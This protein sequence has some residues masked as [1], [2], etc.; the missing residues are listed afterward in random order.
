MSPRRPLA[1]CAALAAGVLSAAA[2]SA[3]TPTFP[4]AVETVRVDVLVTDHRQPLL[5]LAAGDFEVLDNGVPQVV[6][7]VVSEGLPLNVVLALDTSGSLTEQ[8]LE[9][10]RATSRA[11]VSDLKAGDRAALLTFSSALVL[12]AVQPK[13]PRGVMGG[14]SPPISEEAG[15]GRRL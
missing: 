10:L 8:R 14:W 11:I 5:G 9:A 3:Q 7:L 15:E 1:R 4:A 13:Q 12:R 2:A 6:E